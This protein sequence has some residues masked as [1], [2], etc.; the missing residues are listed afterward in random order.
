M[1]KIIAA[2]ILVAVSAFLIWL[3]WIQTKLL[4]VTIG[5]L[6]LS[7]VALYFVIKKM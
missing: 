3:V 2:V 4:A 1:K 5:L 6:L 7:L